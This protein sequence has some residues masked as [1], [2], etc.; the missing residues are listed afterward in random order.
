MVKLHPDVEIGNLPASALPRGRIQDQLGGALLATAGRASTQSPGSGPAVPGQMTAQT[1]GSRSRSL[2]RR[3]F[4]ALLPIVLAVLSCGAGCGKQQ[5]ETNESKPPIHL[6]KVVLAEAM[7]PVCAPVYIAAEKGFFKEE[8]L[9][10]QLASFTKGKLCLDTLLGGKAEFATVAETPLMNVG[11][12]KQPVAILC[13]MLHATN[14]TQCVARKDRGILKPEDLKGHK[15][16]VP[17]GGNA[18]YFMDRLLEKHGLSRQDVTVVNLNPSEMVTVMVRGDIDASFT[19]EPNAIR[20]V[21]QLGNKAI[22]FVGG[23]IYRETFEIAAMKP[24]A[25]GH[26]DDCKRLLR[27]LINAVNFIHANEEESVR[28]VA[29]RIQME[30]KELSAIWG[31]Y[32]YGVSLDQS[33]VGLLS[34]QAKWAIAG[35]MQKGEIPNYQSLLYATPLRSLDPGSVSVKS[36]SD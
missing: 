30:P 27:A 29:K 33:L 25:E 16:G 21:N 10:V 19:W 18:E 15:V 9:D 23:N 12:T 28:I 34:A 7:Q 31:D 4:I 26:Q 36:G 2:R 22:V 11:F 5:L 13:T 8:G 20:T 14:N 17:I 3:P 32:N 6:K 1:A 24:W 35:G